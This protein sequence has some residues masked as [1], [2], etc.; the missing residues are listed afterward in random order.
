MKIS[1]HRIVVSVAVR[2]IQSGG[3]TVGAV[4]KSHP[5]WPISAVNGVICV[6]IVKRVSCS[7]MKHGIFN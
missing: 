4:R 6:R 5:P 1:S 7:W 3:G 2:R